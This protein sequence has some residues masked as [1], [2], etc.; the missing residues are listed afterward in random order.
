MNN[1]QGKTQIPFL[2]KFP[3]LSAVLKYCIHENWGQGSAAEGGLTSQME[4]K[5]WQRRAHHQVAWLAFDMSP[6]MGTQL[7]MTWLELWNCWLDLCMSLILTWLITW[8]KSWDS[9][10]LKSQFSLCVGLLTFFCHIHVVPK[11]SWPIWKLAFRPMATAN[12][13]GRG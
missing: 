2:S 7:M 12:G 4:D 10:W 3:I 6:G 13:V 9:K 11:I 5:E 8:E 1:W